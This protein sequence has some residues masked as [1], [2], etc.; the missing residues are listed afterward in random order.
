MVTSI[1]VRM[2]L[3]KH[4]FITFQLKFIQKSKSIKET[5]KMKSIFDIIFANWR[6]V[7]IASVGIVFDLFF[8][9]IPYPNEKNTTLLFKYMDEDNDQKVDVNEFETYL[10]KLFHAHGMHALNH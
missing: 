3:I 5:T 6:T 1:Q 4:K 2:I 10:I 8:K 9:R 7:S